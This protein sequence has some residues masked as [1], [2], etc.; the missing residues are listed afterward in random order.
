MRVHAIHR[1]VRSS[2][3]IVRSSVTWGLIERAGFCYFVTH[4][5][6]HRWWQMFSSLAVREFN[7]YD[8]RMLAWIAL[9]SSMTRMGKPL[10]SLSILWAREA[11]GVGSAADPGL[12]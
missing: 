3:Q 7:T 10:V 1:R 6:A 2:G 8:E 5:W 9:F 11:P 12:D 4:A